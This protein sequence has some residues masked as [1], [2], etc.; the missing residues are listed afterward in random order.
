MPQ[1]RWRDDH[2]LPQPGLPDVPKCAGDDPNGGEEPR[3]IEYLKTP[4]SRD[5]LV[6]LLRQMEPEVFNPDRACAS[7]K[8]VARMACS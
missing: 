2:D 3:T 4:P 1:A 6:D 5:E 8:S 7:S